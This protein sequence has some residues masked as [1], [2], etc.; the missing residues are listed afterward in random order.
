[1]KRSS[2][3]GQ[4]NAW[5]WVVVLALLLAATAA[6]AG[7]RKP[8]AN[9][10]APWL[11]TVD[12][13]K[14]GDT[15]VVWRDGELVD[16]RLA[17]ADAP[18]T[19][20][21]TCPGQPYGLAALRFAKGLVLGQRVHVLPMGVDKYRRVVAQIVLPDGRDLATEL[22][23]AGLAWVYTEYTP[24]DSPL[25]ALEAEAR[26]HRRGLWRA[27]QPPVNPADHRHACKTQ[28]APAAGRVAVTV[29]G[30]R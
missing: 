12:R 13:V 15:L 17:F 18:E 29:G 1:M 7:Q 2:I 26:M 22:V 6:Q 14:D 11:G 20:K 21:P 30:G 28:R 23:K 8:A 10:P 24:H 5:R 16:I 9:T 25:F 3:L 4:L 27:S 19:V